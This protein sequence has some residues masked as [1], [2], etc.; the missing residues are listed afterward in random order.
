MKYFIAATC[1]VVALVEVQI[2]AQ[3]YN[4][5]S[6]PVYYEEEYEEPSYRVRRDLFGGS[7]RGPGRSFSKN[8]GYQS[9]NT[10][11]S[12]SQSANARGRV[13]PMVYSGGSAINLPGG[14]SI[15]GALD[16]VPKFGSQANIRGT[17]NLFSND[18]HQVSA[19]A[20]HDRNLARNWK[21]VGK[22][23]NT[24]GLNYANQNGASA[25]LSGSKIPGGPSRGSAGGSIP[26]AT[27]GSNARLDAVGQT[28]FGQGMKPEHQVGVQLSADI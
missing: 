18:K 9:G 4:E 7:S 20:Q 24:V 26:I 28:N 23:T 14:H 19:F 15:S 21:P 10:W 27:F 8:V 22:E 11:G 1:F 2:Y 25:F 5:D 3:E 17:A 12:L 16:H 13:N 6:E